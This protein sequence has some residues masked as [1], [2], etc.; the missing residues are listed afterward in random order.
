MV[1][2]SKSCHPSTLGVCAGFLKC[3][4]CHTGSL[5]AC[6]AYG[7]Y[8]FD[9]SVCF[10]FMVSSHHRAQIMPNR[11]GVA[12]WVRTARRRRPRRLQAAPCTCRRSDTISPQEPYTPLYPWLQEHNMD[13]LAICY[14]LPP[15]ARYSHISAMP[16]PMTKEFP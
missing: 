10:N 14:H 6:R 3:P 5:V 2:K 13:C 16:I 8:I 15:H 12:G 1:K 11:R 7:D 9:R 4:R